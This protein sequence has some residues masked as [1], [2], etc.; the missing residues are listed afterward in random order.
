VTLV[1]A[2]EQGSEGASCAM[3]GGFHGMVAQLRVL[4][5]GAR[6]AMAEQPAITSR[7]SPPKAE[8]LAKE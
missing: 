5:R 4:G 3:G 7:E 1:V 2:I 8:R 6:V